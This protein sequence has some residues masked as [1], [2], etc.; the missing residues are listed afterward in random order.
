[1]LTQDQKN[2]IGG[3]SVYTFETTVG[4]FNEPVIVRLAYEYDA[5][6][7][8]NETVDTVRTE[9]GFPIMGYLEE[10][11]IDDLCILGCELLNKKE[12]Y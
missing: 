7:T 6:G 2:T 1:M 9:S 5:S 10:S 3:E 8:Y 12:V 4:L 11:T